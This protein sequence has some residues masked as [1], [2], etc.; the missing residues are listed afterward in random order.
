MVQTEKTVDEFSQ[1]LAKF[2]DENQIAFQGDIQIPKLTT[3][4][5]DDNTECKE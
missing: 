2:M 3:E 5:L 4:E 1:L